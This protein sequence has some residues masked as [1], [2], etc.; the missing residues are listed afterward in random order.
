MTNHTH[1]CTTLFA[2]IDAKDSRGFVTYLSDEAQFRYGSAHPVTGTSAIIAALDAFFASVTALSH[3]IS[4]I[5]EV[6]GHVICRGEVRYERSDG[7]I[8]T[9]PFCNVFTMCAEKI[10]RYEIYLDPTPLVAA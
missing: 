2:T 8:V 1:W 5:W 6:P 4:D 9:A 3:R 10:A 7:N